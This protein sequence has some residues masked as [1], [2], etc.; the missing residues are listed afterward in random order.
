[1][2]KEGMRAQRIMAL[3]KY[4]EVLLTKMYPLQTLHGLKYRTNLEDAEIKNVKHI[5]ARHA[6][7][8]CSVTARTALD[9]ATSVLI[10]LGIE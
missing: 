7:S 2:D 8:V 4:S 10:R 3:T 5:I 6:M 1:M 9:M